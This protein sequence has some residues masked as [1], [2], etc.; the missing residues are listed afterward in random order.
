MLGGC[1]SACRTKQVSYW[2]DEISARTCRRWENQLCADLAEGTPVPVPKGRTCLAW[3]RVCRKSPVVGADRARGR[4]AQRGDRSWTTQGLMTWEPSQHPG[5]RMDMIWVN[6]LKGSSSARILYQD[7]CWRSYFV[8]SE[9]SCFLCMP[10]ATNWISIELK[11]TER[12]WN[13][14]VWKRK[15]LQLP[16][17]NHT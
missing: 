4:G 15:S 13:W 3:T 14:R 1:R 7:Q 10:T 16:E 6:H 8:T 2:E 9:L 12:K 5:P 17:L 11:M